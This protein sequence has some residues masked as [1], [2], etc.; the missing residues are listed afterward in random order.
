MRNQLKATLKY[1]IGSDVYD[2]T[3]YP[4]FHTICLVIAGFLAF[5]TITNALLD[6]NHLLPLIVSILGMLILVFYLSRFRGKLMLSWSIFTISCYVILGLNYFMNEGIDGPTLIVSM[7]MLAGIF[8]AS[9][10]KKKWT[11]MLVH[12]S[13]FGG[14][15]YYE[16][17]HP[18]VVPINYNNDNERY[19]DLFYSYLF[20]AVFIAMTLHIVARSE[21]KQRIQ[22]KGNTELL[23]ATAN[24]LEQ[25]NQ[26]LNRMFSIVSH[27]LR[28]PLISIEG[29]LQHI[30]SEDLDE[31]ERERLQQQL[32]RMVRS[33]SRMLDQLLTWSKGQLHGHV[34]N[35][36][37]ASLNKELN[38]TFL[39]LQEIAKSKGIETQF[40]ISDRKVICDPDMI[41]I[42]IRNLVHNSVKFSNAGTTITVT[43]EVPDTGGALIRVVDEGVGMSKDQIE[44]LFSLNEVSSSYGTANEKGV[45]LGMVLVKEFVALHQGNVECFSQIGKGTTIE[46]S[47]PPLQ[48]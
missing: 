45:G 16:F 48:I 20:S 10:F 27:D 4:T 46:I 24:D 32:L 14:L 23:N 44:K 35:L 6:Q 12:M 28:N 13:I 21:K 31:E 3:D 7:I 34:F 33:T 25:T 41:T 42:I 9:P 37:A 38:E 26:K 29:Y 47:I 2:S 5:G 19:L 43:A 11:W 17:H 39:F 36:K 30:D 1:L 22:L 18:E 8:G 40:K 15:M